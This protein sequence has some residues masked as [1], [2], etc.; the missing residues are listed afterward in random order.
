MKRCCCERVVKL[1][2]N[3]HTWNTSYC[4]EIGEKNKGSYMKLILKRYWEQKEW[5]RINEWQRKWLK[6]TDDVALWEAEG[7]I[8]FL[9]FFFYLQECLKNHKK[10]LP[11]CLAYNNVLSINSK[12]RL[13]ATFGSVLCELAAMLIQKWKKKKLEQHIAITVNCWHNGPQNN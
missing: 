6:V 13:S 9:F 3:R 11:W 12:L 5:Q 1:K 7:F 2:G 4:S 10:L 8:F